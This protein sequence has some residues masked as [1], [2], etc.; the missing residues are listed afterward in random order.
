MGTGTGKTRI[1]V[2]ASKHLIESGSVASI[3]IVVP[4]INLIQ[5]WIAEFIK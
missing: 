5:G 1:G 4:T 3:R 2:L